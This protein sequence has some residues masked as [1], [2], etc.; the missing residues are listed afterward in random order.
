MSLNNV[1]RRV[2]VAMMLNCFWVP[3]ISA[4]NDDLWCYF[5]AGPQPGE[6]GQHNQ[7]L[8]VDWIPLHWMRSSRQILSLGGS[9]ARLHGS[10][11]GEQSSIDAFSV[12]PQLTLKARLWHGAEPLF[13][14]RALGPSYLSE[15]HL[16]RREQAMNFAF[17][18]QVGAALRWDHHSLAL[19][20]RHYSNANVRQP[21]DGFDIPLVI[22]FGVTF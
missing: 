7:L 14:V 15:R 21:N 2:L 20:Y 22:A 1:V 19:W 17:Q 6:A 16:G 3:G 5:G 4:R 8:G 11:D 9:V 18:A 12:F 10:Q 13:M